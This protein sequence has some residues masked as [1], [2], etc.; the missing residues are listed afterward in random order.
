MAKL[1]SQSCLLT[2]TG[3][4]VAVSENIFTL[5]CVIP[6]TQLDSTTVP[7]HA[8]RTQNGSVWRQLGQHFRATDTLA[9]NSDDVSVWELV[10]LW[11]GSVWR[12]E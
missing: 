10:G 7:G 1:A 11:A 3:C 12:Q 8:R 5:P 9:A 6:M 2:D 4:H